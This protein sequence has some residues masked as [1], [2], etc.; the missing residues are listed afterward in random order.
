MKRGKRGRKSLLASACPAHIQPDYNQKHQAS[1]LPNASKLP[2][3]AARE[4]SGV[5]AMHMH[6]KNQNQCQP[7]QSQSESNKQ[8]AAASQGC[9]PCIRHSLLFC[10]QEKGLSKGL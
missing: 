3:R 6:P 2:L 1:L 7:M 4:D 10:C 8:A 9:L 5:R